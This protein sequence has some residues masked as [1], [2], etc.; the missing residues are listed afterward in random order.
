MAE[1]EFDW[2]AKAKERLHIFHAAED[3]Y[4]ADLVTRSKKAIT[5]MTGASDESNESFRELVLERVRYAYNDSLEYFETN[6]RTDI[7][8]LSFTEYVKGGASD[9]LPTSAD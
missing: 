1:T 5:D 9:E 3:D 6:F 7:M 4:I 2:T 8:Q